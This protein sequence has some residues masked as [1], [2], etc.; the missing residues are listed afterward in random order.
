MAKLTSKKRNSLPKGDFAGADRSY[1]VNDKSHARNAL[2]RAS[3]MENKG[4]L[5]ASSKAKIDAKA[6]RVLD[7]G[8]RGSKG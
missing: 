7:S 8:K 1:P 5:S 4:K 2:A 3:E 6:H